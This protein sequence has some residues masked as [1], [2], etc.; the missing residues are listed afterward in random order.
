MSKTLYICY[1]GVRE[2]L[3]QT[4][5]IPYL[6]EIAKDGVGISLLTFE[7]TPLTDVEASTVRGELSA[8]GI[9]WHSLRYHKRLSVIATAY[10]VFQGVRL[11]RQLLRR[12]RFDILHA[13]VHIPMLMAAL[14]R[15]LSPVKPKLLFDIRGFFPEEY[16]DA[17]V[18][19]PDGLLYRTVKRV[20]KWLMKEADGFVVIDGVQF[21]PAATADAERAAQRGSGFTLRDTKPAIT[22]ADAMTPA[23]AARCQATMRRHT[24]PNA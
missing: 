7:P 8:K 23:S 13:R 21:V 3:V 24:R 11:G 22:A 12:E 5:V 18:W 2:P 19:K 20:E 17:G 9:T 4:Q 6:L 16:T 10:D 1:F 15:K 14:V